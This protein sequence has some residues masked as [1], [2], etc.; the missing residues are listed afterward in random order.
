MTSLTFSV[1]RSLARTWGSGDEI[2]LT[3]LDHDANVSPWLL[4]ARDRGVTVRW[5]DFDP[6]MDA[7]LDY[8]GLEDV[9][10]PRTRLVAVT[11]AS[12]A[13]G[14]VV[15]WSHDRRGESS[16][17]VDVRGCGALCAALQ[18]GCGGPRH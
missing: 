6:R 7:R 13:T 10:G 8:S 2:V 14:T 4:A 12:N 18:A 17:S 15:D 3:R 16:G 1:S 9:I 5:L 11:H